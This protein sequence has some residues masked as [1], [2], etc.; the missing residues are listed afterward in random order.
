MGRPSLHCPE[1]VETICERLG[2]GQSLAAICRA[3]DMPSVRTFLKWADEK[4][5]V[6]AEYTRALAARGE[7]FAAEHDRIRK[8]AN[9]RDSAAAARVQLTALEWQMSKMAPKRYGDRLDV[10]VDASL[11]LGALIDRGR[12]RVIE[13]RQSEDP[14]LPS[15]EG[16]Q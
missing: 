10:N 6:A 2:K 7:W 1:V 12:Q 11:D 13:G 9:D 16:Q 15:P 4:D 8:T 3:A 5:D 14:A